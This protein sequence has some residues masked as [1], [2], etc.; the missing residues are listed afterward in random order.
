M[1]L[2]DYE[3]AE[4]LQKGDIAA[5]AAT[6]ADHYGIRLPSNVATYNVPT[7]GL[8]RLELF[9]LDCM[10]TWHAGS[11]PR[12]FTLPFRNCKRTNAYSYCA[13]E[14]SG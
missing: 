5:A 6:L 8:L 14:D 13:Q 4:A 2:F 7:T 12:K 1:K 9:H 3:I 11:G 10:Y